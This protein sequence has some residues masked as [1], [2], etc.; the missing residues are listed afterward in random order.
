M[1]QWMFGMVAVL[2]FGAVHAATPATVVL[3]AANMTCPTCNITIEK[4][5]GRV[6]G[7]TSAKVDLRAQTVTIAFDAERTTSQVLADT[8]TDAGF[9][10]TVDARG[11]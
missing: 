3:H 11:G 9:P 6:S 8:V 7:V 1:R 5:L 10:A 2:W 4:A